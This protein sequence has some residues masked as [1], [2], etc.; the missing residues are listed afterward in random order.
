ML[1]IQAPSHGRP[2]KFFS[3]PAC[4]CAHALAAP[5][6]ITSK[7]L[8]TDEFL[9]NANKSLRS[10]N[11]ERANVG[12]QWRTGNKSSWI[13]WE[14]WVFMELKPWP[15]HLCRCSCGDLRNTAGSRLP[16]TAS[17]RRRHRHSAHILRGI[18]RFE[19]SSRLG[20]RHIYVVTGQAVC[21]DRVEYKGDCI[22]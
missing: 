12:G 17:T 21:G 22:N 8:A 18:W 19:T 3:S 15:V 5:L 10:I 9:T 6:A 1:I 2:Q 7:T 4:G 13:L 20:S 14:D 16:R 11:F